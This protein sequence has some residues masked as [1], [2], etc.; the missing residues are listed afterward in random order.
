[1]SGLLRVLLQGVTE[2]LHWE[3]KSSILGDPVHK[4]FTRMEPRKH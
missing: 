2:V 4:L 1:M 3:D